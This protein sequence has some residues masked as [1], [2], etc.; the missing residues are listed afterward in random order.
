MNP[1][2]F[3]FL[4]LFTCNS[5]CQ[6]TIFRYEE[7][8]IKGNIV[9]VDTNLI[10][11]QKGDII[12]DVPIDFVYGYKRDGVK[13]ILYQDKNEPI[14]L[15]QMDDYVMGRVDGFKNHISG[16]PFTIGFFSSFFYTYHNTRGLTRNPKFS[17]L[18]FTAVPPIVFTILKPKTD[19]RWSNERR[20]G[21]RTSRSERNQ[22]SSFGGAL[23]GTAFIYSIYFSSN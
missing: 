19:K 6:D 8:P 4:F 7:K 13:T 2:F 15:K 14:T 10:L 16:V 5:F 1:I 23:L 3:I 22:I 9:Y 11:Y 18:A 12:K 17:S 20:V 21:Y